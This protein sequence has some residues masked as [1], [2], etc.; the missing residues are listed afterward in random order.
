MPATQSIALLIDADNAP[1]A[2]LDFIMAELA[3][4][5]VVNIRRAYGNWKKSELTGWEAVLL[6]YSIQP[7]QQYDLVKQKNAADM[8]LVVDAMDIL[9]TKSVSVFCIVSSDCDFTPLTVR[10]RAEGRTVI[11]FGG[12]KTPPPFVNSC[13]RFLYL[14]E[15]K[16]ATEKRKRQ[17]T[18]PQRLKGDAKLMQTLRGA[19]EASE[20]ENEDGWARLADVGSHIGNQ[21]GAF[22]HRNYG[23]KKL[24]DLFASIDLF[25]LRSEKQ[26]NLTAVWVRNRKRP[27]PPAAPP[28]AVV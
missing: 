9:Y 26:G 23:F 28:S 2:K 24:S 16:E 21:G 20:N 17:A 10:L 27:K 11:G 5:G 13:S 19:V 3:A 4:Y 12:Q 8:A 14:D 22:D 7:V 1:A 18:D 6:D 15:N 25:E